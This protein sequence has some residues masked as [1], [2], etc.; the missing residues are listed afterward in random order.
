MAEER[1]IKQRDGPA[2]QLANENADPCAQLLTLINCQAS[3]APMAPPAPTRGC[4]PGGSVKNHHPDA[5]QRIHAAQSQS[6]DHEW[7]EVLQARHSE[8]WTPSLSRLPVYQTAYEPARDAVGAVSDGS[9]F[10]IVRTLAIAGS[11]SEMLKHCSLIT[12]FPLFGVV[13]QST[14]FGICRGALP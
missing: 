14:L 3:R 4:A 11:A 7:L 9:A 8:P 12:I 13:V 1:A 5:G 2:E 10:S 6:G